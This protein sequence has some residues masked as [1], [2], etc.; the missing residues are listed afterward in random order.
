M[1]D[2]TAALT[3]EATQSLLHELQVHQIELEMQNDE[4]RRTHVELDTLRGRYFELY[5]LAPVG[6]VTL[7]EAGLI[8]EANL[9]AATLLGVPRGE[10]VRQAFTRYIHRDDEDSYYLYRKQLRASQDTDTGDAGTPQELQLRMVKPDGTLIWVALQTLAVQIAADKPAYRV[11]MIDITARKQT[12]EALRLSNE[13]F[14]TLA[15][16][17]PVGIYLTDPDG[18]CRYANPSWCEMAGLSMEQALASGW[19]GSLHPDDRDSV[20]AS[21]QHM[22]ESHGHWGMEYRFLTPNGM[23]TWVYGLATPQ[24]DATGSI[25]GYVGVNVDVTERKQL[26]AV[27]HF[28]A[29]TSGGIR[30]DPFF[31]ALAAYLASSL[32]MDFVCIDRLESDGLNAHTVAIW[33]DGHFEDNMSYP[34]KDTPV[35]LTLGQHI[36]CFPAKVCELFPHDLMLRELGAESYIGTTLWSHAGQAIGLITLTS[37]RPLTNRALAEATLSLVAERAAG[38]L[39]RL[40]AEQA[41]TQSLLEKDSLLQEIHH[42]VKNNLQIISSLLRL[43]SNQI[44]NRIAKNALQDMQNR[45]LSMALIHEQLYG[46]KNFAAVDMSAYLTQLCN[47]LFHAL[48]A[49]CGRVQLHLNLAPVHLEIDKAIPCGLLVNELVTNVFKHAFPAERGGELRVELQALADAPGWRLLVADTGVGLPPDFALDAINSLG[50]KL[51]TSL[52][53]QI[54]GKL[55]FRPGP[56]TVV[57]MEVRQP[58]K[59]VETDTQHLAANI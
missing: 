6:Y 51:V 29:R 37:R 36:C 33:S 42:R 30:D 3:P 12:E 16:L 50:L 57:E 58:L 7:S 43:Q 54:G 26:D 21:W 34:L 2:G 17:A 55:H 13:Y 39:E 32:E 10:L 47:Q 49:T 20:F 41:L 31:H 9:A 11:V 24:F 38:E 27:Q 14:Q 45:V 15:T 53:R 44:D 5:D 1:A 28:L 23:V 56:G 18:G 40:A 19:A 8:A 4:L 35:G 22:V 48:A 46:T 52:T 59:A 25:L